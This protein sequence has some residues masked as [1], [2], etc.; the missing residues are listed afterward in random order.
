MASPIFQDNTS[1]PV[2]DDSQRLAASRAIYTKDRVLVQKRVRRDGAHGDDL[3][4][5]GEP[6]EVVCSVED[7]AQQAGMFS[8]SGQED[9]TIGTAGG[10]QEVT[11]IQ[12][13]ALDWPGDIDSLIWWKG[14]KYD[15]DGA[16][17][18]RSHGLTPHWE[19]RARRVWA[20]DF[21]VSPQP[22][23]GDD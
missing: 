7:R 9:K 17:V 4:E 16:P 20:R 11:P 12:I 13:M 5:V 8:I 19:I 22:M 23:T 18:H 14:D 15:A 6:V 3:I 21:A 1:P 2:F 10:L